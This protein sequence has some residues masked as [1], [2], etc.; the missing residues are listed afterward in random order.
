M[1]NHLLIYQ[2]PLLRF[3]C[4][5]GFLKVGLNCNTFVVRRRYRWW[6]KLPRM[7][8]FHPNCPASRKCIQ[9]LHS[10]LPSLPE[11]WREGWKNHGPRHLESFENYT[12]VPLDSSIARCLR[13]TEQA[14][15]TEGTKRHLGCKD[16]SYETDHLFSKR[17][18][19]ITPVRA[20]EDL[21]IKAN[22]TCNSQITP[23]RPPWAFLSVSTHNKCNLCLRITIFIS[24]EKIPE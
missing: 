8:F 20:A 16:G 6:K 9:R 17:L 19:L 3:L 23:K 4:V 7:R 5:L 13:R 21:S 2:F 15:S 18:I 10:R 22:R 1:K 12:W 11:K 14:F 24:P